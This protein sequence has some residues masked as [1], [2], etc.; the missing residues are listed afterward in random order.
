MASNKQQG[1]IY[2]KRIIFW[3]YNSF[4]RHYR[5]FTFICRT[6]VLHAHGWR[7]YALPLHFR[8]RWIRWYRNRDYGYRLLFAAQSTQSVVVCRNYFRRYHIACSNGH[9]RGLSPSSH[10]LPFDIVPRSSTDWNRD[11]TFRNR[12]HRFFSKPQL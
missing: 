9:R 6:S 4:N 5:I 2:D 12:K 7:L 8:H 11:C 10:A 3:I 1:G